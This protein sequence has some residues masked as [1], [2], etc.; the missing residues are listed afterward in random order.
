MD[1]NSHALSYR[2]KALVA[3]ALDKNPPEPAPEPVPAAEIA[4][5]ARA[6]IVAHVP[7]GA[8]RERILDIFNR[9]A[10]GQSFRQIRKETK[11]SK[12]TVSYDLHVVEKWTGKRFLRSGQSKSIKDAIDRVTRV[13]RERGQKAASIRDWHA[14]R[15]T[16]VTPALSAGVPMELVRRVTGHATVEVVLKHYFR[17]DREQFKAVLAAAMPDVLTGKAAVKAL[18]PARAAEE[19][20]GYVEQPSPSELLEKAL[21]ELR[22]VKTK[23]KHLAEGI[24]LVEAAKA[25]VDQPSPKL[26]TA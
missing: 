14:L 17:P 16:F 26:A 22:A 1:R 3:R 13:T 18:P 15:T 12:S 9:Y 23:C 2:F 4:D 5:E 6:A 7:E 19:S 10:E 24:A 21:A 11:A 20:A 25:Y 8:R